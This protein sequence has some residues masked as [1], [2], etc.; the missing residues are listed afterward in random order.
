MSIVGGLAN[1]FVESEPGK[2]AREPTQPG[3]RIPDPRYFQDVH[4]P[5]THNAF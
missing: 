3:S 2:K 5:G 1:F 4:P